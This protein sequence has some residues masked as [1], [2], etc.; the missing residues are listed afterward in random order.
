MNLSFEEWMADQMP[1]F[2]RMIMEDIRPTDGW[3]K[4]ATLEQLA[5][6]CREAVRRLS[7]GVH[8]KPTKV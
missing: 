5:W 6:I 3:V 7:E 2:D 1:F 8:Y 4:V